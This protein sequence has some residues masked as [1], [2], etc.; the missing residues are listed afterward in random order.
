MDSRPGS[1]SVRGEAANMKNGPLARLQFVTDEFANLPITRFAKT[2][3]DF[4]NR[5]LRG[6]QLL[7]ELFKSQLSFLDESLVFFPSF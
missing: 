1:T 2:L 4:S 6:Q 5:G 3:W 7:P